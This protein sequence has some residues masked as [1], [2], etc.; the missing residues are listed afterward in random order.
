MSLK[1]KVYQYIIHTRYHD[2][3]HRSKDLYLSSDEALEE[4]KNLSKNHLPFKEMKE[5]YFT[6]K[7]FTVIIKSKVNT[8]HLV[9]AVV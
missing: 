1:R 3:I 2:V 9:D 4:A 6:T 7:E 5:N 8:K